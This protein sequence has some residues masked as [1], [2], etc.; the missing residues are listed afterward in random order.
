MFS[1]T[2]HCRRCRLVTS[3]NQCFVL[4]LFLFWRGKSLLIE[5]YASVRNIIKKLFTVQ[6][7]QPFLSLVY[8]TNTQTEYGY[9]HSQHKLCCDETLSP[10]FY[11]N[12]IFIAVFLLKSLSI[13][14]DTVCQHNY[15]VF[16]FQSAEFFLNWFYNQRLII[17]PQVTT[18]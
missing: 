11:Y 12:L 18:N 3:L 13:A 14:C 7:I 4:F 8:M 6:L 9:W 10:H 2:F 1:Y 15:Y 16:T 5:E 17:I